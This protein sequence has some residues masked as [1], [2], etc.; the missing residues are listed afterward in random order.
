MCRSIIVTDFVCVRTGEDRPAFG[1]SSYA[2]SEDKSPNVHT[3]QV[4][5]AM[6]TTITACRE[7]AVKGFWHTVIAGGRHAQKLIVARD[8]PDADMG[9]HTLF[10]KVAWLLLQEI[11]IK[12]DKLSFGFIGDL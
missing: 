4:R 9:F 6:M 12:R 8:V 2:V 7:P 5:L 10:E 1:E 11:R 3:R